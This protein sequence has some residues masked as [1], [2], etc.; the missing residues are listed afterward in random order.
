MEEKKRCGGTFFRII[1]GVIAGLVVMTAFSLV[2]GAIAMVLWNWLM[3]DIFELGRID[4]WQAFGIVL[5]AKL[6]FGGFGKH[7][8]PPFAGRKWADR[9]WLEY[10]KHRGFSHNWHLDD[11]Y[12]EWW[13]KQGSQS[14]DEY[15]KEKHRGDKETGEKE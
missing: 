8:P 9:R 1:G 3:P 4:Y 15:M 14:F 13:K 7:F 2:I 6:V 11:D 12:E 5:L 10:A